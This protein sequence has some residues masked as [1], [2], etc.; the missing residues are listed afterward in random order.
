M[1]LE[2]FS[3]ER[4]YKIRDGEFPIVECMMGNGRRRVLA[5]TVKV[6]TY[7]AEPWHAFVVAEGR[8]ILRD[9]RSG[10]RTGV[11]WSI[12]GR[13]DETATAPEWVI[14]AAR[15]ALDGGA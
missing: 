6:S 14:A 11:S 12:G 7:P 4:E 10:R 2:H 3:T 15:R 8:T 13:W 5:D 9:G 1:E